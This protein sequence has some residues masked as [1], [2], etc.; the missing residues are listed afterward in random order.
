MVIPGTNS[1]TPTIITTTYQ[2]SFP[3]TSTTTTTTTTTTT[4]VTTTANNGGSAL[5]CPHCDRTFTARIGLAGHC[6]CGLTHRMGLFGHMR[7]HDSG[8]HRN[9]NNT[10]TLCTSSAP[11]ILT[12]TATSTTM[13]DIPHLSQFL[14]PTLHFTSHIGLLGHL[15]IHRTET[16]EQVTGVPK[17]SRHGRLHCPHCSRTFPGCMGLLGYML[18]HDNPR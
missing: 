2:Y 3:M 9:A 14:L 17:Y 6:P 1:P 4:P 16:G 11:D 7:M 8:I 15:R 18:L 5:I 13:N 12:A 10:D